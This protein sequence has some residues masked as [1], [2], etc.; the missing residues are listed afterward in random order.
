MSWEM[1]VVRVIFVLVLTAASFHLQP[2]NLSSWVAGLLGAVLGIFFVLF[3]LRLERASLKRLLGAA[4]G[5][6]LG[7]AGALMMGH[8]LNLTAIDK[9]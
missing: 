5:S 2:F 1:V 4:V 9:N 6:I 3:E 8:L 7:I